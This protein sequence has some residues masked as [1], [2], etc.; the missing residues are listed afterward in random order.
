M[1][2]Y[3]FLTVIKLALFAALL[4][5][6]GLAQA[7]YVGETQTTKYLTKATVDMISARYQAG[8]G[9]L[10]A[11]DE[12]SYIIQ[13]TPTD[14][15]GNVGA[16]AWV[17]DYIPAGT[18]VVNAQ[19]VQ[20][21]ADGSTTQIAPPGVAEVLA[22]YVPMYSDTG[23]F[24]STDPRTNYYSTPAG[25]P[26]SSNPAPGNGYSLPGVAT[27]PATSTHNSW[28]KSMFTAYVA[29]AR[30]PARAC[31][32]AGAYA[33][34]AGPVAGSD[35]FLKTDYTGS[36]GPW[37]R[38]SYPGSMMGTSTGTTGPGGGC[39]G[40]TPTMA[41]YPLSSSNPLPSNT[42]A[43][44]FAGGKATVGELFSVLITLRLTQPLPSTGLINNS[45]VFG[46]DT[47][48][49]NGAVVGK[50]SMWKYHGPS[51]ASANTTLTVLKRVVGMCVGVGCVPQAFSGGAVPAA[52]NLK[53]RYE[54]LYLNS[55]GATQ[56]NV[57]LTDTAMPTG[58][59]LVANS[60]VVVNG[61]NVL[62]T[63]GGPT[64]SF[65]FAPISSLGSG[66]GGSVQ[67]DVTFAAAP[68]ANVALSNTAKLTSFS[69]PTGVTS[70][71]TVTA[72]T[73]ANLN[74]SK[75][76]STP[77]RTPSSVANYTIT[78]ANNG[79][80]AATAVTVNDYLPSSGGTTVAER[81]A[82][83]AGAT[84]TATLTTAAG[85]VTALTVTATA[86]TTLTV[87]TGIDAPYNNTNREKV[88][89]TF[90]GVGY[91]G[92]PSGGYITL[93]YSA[94]VG[95]NVPQ[96]AAPYPNDVTVIYTGGA[97]ANAQSVS[98]GVAPVTVVVPLT[99]TKN[100]DCVYAGTPAVCQ[101]YANGSNIPTG[102]KVR[103]RLTYSNTAASALSNVSLTD[104]LP[105][106]TTFVVGTATE[107]GTVYGITPPVVTGL[108]ATGQL[109]TFPVISTLAAGATGA[110]TF[111]VQLDAAASLPSGSYITNNAKL[112]ATGYTG[113][114]TASLTSSVLDQAKLVMTKT[115]ST[116]TIGVNGTA[117]YKI[118]V[119]NTGAVAATG[120]KVYD[121]LPFTGLLANLNTRFN[122]TVGST[123]F[124]S[125]NVGG[126]LAVPPA[127]T[128]N[129]A[130]A[131]VAPNLFSPYNT[132]PNQ[133][134]VLWT[135]LA[136]QTLAPGASFTLDFTAA[137]GA[138]NGIPAGS[139]IYT[140][141]AQVV[142]TS[143]TTTL[144]AGVLKSAPVQIPT[145]LSIVKTIECVYNNAGTSCL[146]YSGNG[147]VRPNAK[148]RYKLTY[149]NT[150]ATL[151]QTNVILSDI[152]PTQTAAGSVSNIVYVS[153]T[154]PPLGATN[155]TTPAISAA[156][157]LAAGTLTF[158]TIPSLAANTGGV[159]TFDVQ[160]NAA[161][162]ATIT[163]TGKIVSTSAPN[164]ETSVVSVIALA[165][166]VLEVTK[167]TTAT[168]SLAPNAGVQ[169]SI[170]VTNN[171]AA[172]TTSLRI[173]DF[174]PYTGTVDD[175][176]KRF[177]WVT[178]STGLH[179][180][181][182]CFP[183]PVLPVTTAVVP[184]TLAPYSSNLNQ[185]QI[186][187]DCP[188]F[189]LGVGATVSLDF[190]A[191]VGSAMPAGV[192]G[193]S[194]QADFDS[195]SGSGG[196]VVN[197]QAPVTIAVG[198]NVSGKVY[199]DV[200]FNYIADVAESWAGA[201]NMFVKIAPYSAGSCAT[202][203]TAFQ[204]IT[205]P[206]GTYS[207]AAIPAGQ[208]C[209]TL[210]TNNT[211]AD[212]A[213]IAPAGWVRIAPV[214]GILTITVTDKD[215]ANQNFGLSS[216]SVITGRVFRDT[217][218]GSGGVANDGIQNGTELGNGGVTVTA[219]HASCTPTTCVTTT[220]GNGDYVLRLPT[221]VTGVIT[222][223]ETNPTGMLSTGG[224]VGNSAGSYN[225]TTDAITFTVV[226]G[227]T[228]TAL[229]FADVPV[230]QF[231]T[232]GAQAATAGSVVFYPHRYIAGT[233]ES[234]SFAL[235]AVASPAIVGWSEVLYVDANCNAVID[236]AEVIVPAS[237]PLTAGQEVCLLVKEF[238]PASAALNAQNSVTITANMST[239][240]SG[241]GVNFSYVHRDV[242][243]VGQPTS[244]G[245]VLVKSVDKT[246]AMPDSNLVYTI[247]YTN[248]SSGAL[249]NV[250]INDMT[251]AYTLYQGASCGVLP[252]N[253]TGCTITAPAPDAVGSIIYTF[254][255]TL[256]PTK[257]GAVTFTVKVQP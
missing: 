168:T 77:S 128:V 216:G 98:N 57:Q 107:V 27:T 173:Y 20:I 124:V 46:G 129:M 207:F 84:T 135:F 34:G 119:T 156:S 205:A 29:A 198:Q 222:L 149:Q 170:T 120:I 204:P 217:G 91:T 144:Y 213:A 212:V 228:Y 158:A 244:A 251:P 154:T 125:Q 181:A 179:G 30:V 167:T 241:A 110:V 118:T 139:T 54:I 239:N 177:S 35:A 82:Y 97:G 137:A 132:N 55:S 252:S 79:L 220:D 136:A 248:N 178:N 185:Q 39:I 36:Q 96:R 148:I 113:G 240:F 43:V 50:D 59:S 209:L 166:P 68:G 131:N 201:P 58:G 117:S 11:G 194:V 66:A 94:T 186:K 151:A 75:I 159:I 157:P 80:A 130:S 102:S 2:L 45:E 243:T 15:G 33:A 112:T 146:P 199:S 126:T 99:L 180:F 62:P 104:N 163:N 70:V 73:T 246:T 188:G 115:T 134:Q 141:D 19:F 108:P 61:P 63:T 87:G 12:I 175:A 89:F 189:Q 23:I 7:D 47:S 256:A 254:A 247:A 49:T 24:Y 78:I 202:T 223:T 106:K 142:Y 161:A 232:D 255:G 28:D 196:T 17:T 155:G 41:G 143:G 103:Y 233:A 162:N 31:T 85:V 16:G 42:T 109:M 9:G 92:I 74:T 3:R 37:Q 210:S 4:G 192:Y 197:M 215:L 86:P 245:L 127:P 229:N 184:P 14:N 69:L 122:F 52:A 13:F 150:H 225:R 83:L 48:L 101:P 190:S 72:S 133:T 95:N 219:A 182:G 138:A 236:A 121:W 67:F 25:S 257:S 22:G 231:M 76:T 200:N 238:V 53:L 100:I 230:D 227:A 114:V 5:A 171:G 116:P 242:T 183:G 208:Y 172:P 38:I 65:S 226:A 165:V 235:S 111:D 40:G 64:V 56:T 169:Y 164:G 93:N 51:A 237:M 153:G 105:P 191:T 214:G 193:N 203:A 88:V 8:L 6:F 21:N 174:L 26:I 221:G 71:A 160:T 32:L 140:N 1:N 18:E 44:R 147:I 253:F 234:V 187:W 123:I 152:L 176:T 250:I 195:A 211:L 145:N 90:S 224:T 10:V 206:N 249:S 60:A 218:V 81:F